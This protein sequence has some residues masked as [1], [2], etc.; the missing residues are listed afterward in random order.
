MIK[1]Y[2]KKFFYNIKTIE[3]VYKINNIFNNQ[4]EIGKDDIKKSNK[5]NNKKNN[6]KIYNKKRGV[7]V[8]KIEDINSPK[9]NKDNYK[10]FENKIDKLRFKLINYF[11]F[12]YSKK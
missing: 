1:K 4:K 6:Y 11:I 7:K 12:F 9:N 8:N 10:I 5:D 2:K 3:L